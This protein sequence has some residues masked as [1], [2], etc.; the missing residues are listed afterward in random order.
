MPDVRTGR[1]TPTQ[2][3]RVSRACKRGAQTLPGHDRWQFLDRGAS[4][5]AE[6][7]GGML[8]LRAVMAS[9]SV[10]VE[11]LSHRVYENP[12]RAWS[13]VSGRDEDYNVLPEIEGFRPEPHPKG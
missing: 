7:R 8:P 4:G 10:G 3:R 5:G 9:L 1:W 2:T 6:N 12:A 13:L 11:Q